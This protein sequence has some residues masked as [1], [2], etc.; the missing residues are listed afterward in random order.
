MNPLLLLL[1]MAIAHLA[2]IISEA[3]ITQWL[4]DLIKEKNMV[5]LHE[6]ISCSICVSTQLSLLTI[7][8]LG[9]PFYSP[10]EYLKNM[11]IYILCSMALSYLAVICKSISD[12]LS[13][14]SQIESVDPSDIL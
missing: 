13:I 14:Y 10:H 5:F 1:P 4:R 3:Y 7:L 8:I 12:L 9:T 6:G 11:A 2:Y